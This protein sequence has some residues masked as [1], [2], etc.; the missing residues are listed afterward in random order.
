[1]NSSKIFKLS[2][3]AASIAVSVNA[4]AALYKVVE[5]DQ[6]YGNSEYYGTAVQPSAAGESCFSSE[7][8]D[9]QYKISAETRNW[10]AGLSYREEVPFALD[11]GFDYAA[12][13]AADFENYCDNYLGYAICDT[14]AQ[15]QYSGYRNELDGNY[16][17]QL[18]SLREAR[19]FLMT[20]RL[21]IH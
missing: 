8:T 18:H 6:P 3:V 10:P 17:T 13:D 9:T 15:T 2:V 20:M 5:I 4:Q 12:Y 19:R 21:S 7:C 11:N 16:K 14:W 1:M